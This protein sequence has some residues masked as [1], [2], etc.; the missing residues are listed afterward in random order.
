MLDE[1]TGL[2]RWIVATIGCGS[3]LFSLATTVAIVWVAIHF[4][5][6]YW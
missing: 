2:P 3:I 4:I 5:A 1:D 6:K